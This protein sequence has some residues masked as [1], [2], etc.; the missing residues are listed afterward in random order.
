MY[1]FLSKESSL[2][3][4]FFLCMQKI[5]NAHKLKCR[6]VHNNHP[7]LVVGPIKEEEL[8]LDPWIVMYH[9]VVTDS[10]IKDIKMLATPRV[11]EILVYE[12]AS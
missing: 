4:Y 12:F 11:G 6:Y 10:E 2:Y 1:L 3:G 5:R 8:H 7:L 9:D